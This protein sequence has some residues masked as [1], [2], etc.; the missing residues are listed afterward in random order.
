VAPCMLNRLTVA[1]SGRTVRPMTPSTPASKRPILFFSRTWS[2][3]LVILA[4]GLSYVIV[5]VAVALLLAGIGGGIPVE[6]VGSGLYLAVALALPV[7][8]YNG[9]RRRGE[10]PRVAT[11]AAALAV[12]LLNLAVAPVAIGALSM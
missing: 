1:A 9:A 4:A 11:R 7:S 6:A 8:V 10:P 5:V 3:A 2:A 12:L